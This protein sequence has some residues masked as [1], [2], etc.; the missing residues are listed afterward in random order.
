V[1][2]RL[3]SGVAGDARERIGRRRHWFLRRPPGDPIA[4]RRKLSRIA[5]A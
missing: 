1:V 4:V 3:E 5:A 2:E